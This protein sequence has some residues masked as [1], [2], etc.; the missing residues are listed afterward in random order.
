MD[1]PATPGRPLRADARRNQRR[2][3]ATAAEVFAERGT[4][5]SLEEVAR[6]AQVG[7]GTLYRHFPT[8]DALVE[9]LLHDRFVRL[10]DRATEL[11]AAPPAH[12]GTASELTGEAA[13]AVAVLGVWLAEFAEVA[14]VYRGLPASVMATM[15]DETSELH[16][17]CQAVRDAGAELLRHAK[18]TGAVRADARAADLLALVNAIA[19][20]SE[21]SPADPGRTDR[22]LGLV[23][24]GL[25][26]AGTS[27]RTAGS[28]VR[29]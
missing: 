22:L 18:D 26:A 3:L 16:S 10:R 13:G 1:S 20:I 2:L 9:A 7:I 12:A 4:D 25:S 15:C 14:S 11:R 24:A 6:R 23:L 5:A 19:W 21:Q 29:S 17:A 27:R 28:E 8:R